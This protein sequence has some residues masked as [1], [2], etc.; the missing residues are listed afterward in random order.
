M[1]SLESIPSTW[2]GDRDEPFFRIT[3][4]LLPNGLVAA[5]SALLASYDDDVVALHA[6]RTEA[7]APVPTQPVV[8]VTA[9]DRRAG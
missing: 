4:R 8:S 6:M 7:A 9:A 1:T 3:A 2:D 5:A